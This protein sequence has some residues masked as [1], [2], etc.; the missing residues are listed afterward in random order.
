MADIALL[1]VEELERGT[2]RAAA[3]RRRS[4]ELPGGDACCHASAFASDSDTRKQSAWAMMASVPGVGVPVPV[5]GTET[6]GA[7]GLAAAAAFFSA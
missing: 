6:A 5:P 4:Q 1:V 3:L 2:K 7:L